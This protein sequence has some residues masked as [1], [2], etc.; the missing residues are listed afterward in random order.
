LIP[1]DNSI[2]YIVMIS[3]HDSYMLSH[4]VAEVMG[5]TTQTLYNWLRKGKVPEPKRHPITRYRLWT[6][7]D[8]QRI[9]QLLMAEEKRR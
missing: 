5:V 1:G 9:Q 6:P 8:V 3:A 4:E 2:Y 7:Q